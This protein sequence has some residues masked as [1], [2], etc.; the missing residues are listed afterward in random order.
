MGLN[1]GCCCCLNHHMLSPAIR[2]IPASPPITPPAIAPGDTRSERSDEVVWY[3]VIRSLSAADSK[4]RKSV[5]KHCC[6]PRWYQLVKT[7]YKTMKQ[8]NNKTM[9]QKSCD[10]RDE[11]SNSQALTSVYTR[12]EYVRVDAFLHI[13]LTCTQS[14]PSNKHCHSSSD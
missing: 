13:L 11:Q 6:Y 5:G 4:A 8:G 12:V 2:A 7:W 14:V 10:C 1:R 3:L 9:K